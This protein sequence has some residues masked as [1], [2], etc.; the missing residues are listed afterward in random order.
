MARP[1]IESTVTEKVAKYI[2]ESVSLPYGEMPLSTLAVAKAIGHDRR[3]LKKYGLDVVLSAADRKASRGAKHARDAKRRS[4][5]ERIGAEKQEN[6]KLARQ[7]NSL[8]AQLALVEGNA[9]RLGVDPEE[10]YKPITPPDRR[11]PSI[12]KNKGKRPGARH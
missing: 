7:V 11:V 10:L 2:E 9:K 1:S 12:F 3:V 8:L 5:E 4:L 6:E